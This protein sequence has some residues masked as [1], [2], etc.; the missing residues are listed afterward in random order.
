MVIA[1]SLAFSHSSGWRTTKPKWS[2]AFISI[3]IWRRPEDIAKKSRGLE[4]AKEQQ[5]PRVARVV[6]L[7]CRGTRSQCPEAADEEEAVKDRSADVDAADDNKS[8]SLP[9][10]GAGQTYRVPEI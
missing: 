4:K 7:R 1:F 5:L 9:L 10:S 2:T 8:A 3:W 6:V